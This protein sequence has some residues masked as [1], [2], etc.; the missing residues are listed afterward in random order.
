MMKLA[1]RILPEAPNIRL[2]LLN[3]YLSLSYLSGCALP[4]N[5]V[6]IS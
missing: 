1:A 4:N 3:A 6:T 2:A 5:I